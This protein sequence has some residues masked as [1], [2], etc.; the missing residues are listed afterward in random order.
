MDKGVHARVLL[1]GE[2]VGVVID[3]TEARLPSIAHW[4]ADPGELSDD[5][6]ADLVLAASPPVTPSGVDVPVRLAILPEQHTGWVGRPGLS[7]ARDG[8]DFSP[9][10]RCTTLRLDGA[11]VDAAAAEVTVFR[12]GTGIV[13]VTAQDEP[14]GLRLEIEI[15]L[16][17]GGVLR[18]RAT[19]T[20]T[21]VEPYRLDQLALAL[22]VPA[23]ARDLL[24][25][26]GRWGKERVPQRRDFTVGV[27]L[28]EGRRGRTGA[29]AATVL[30]AGEPGFGFRHGQVWG[31]HVGWS[32]N[33]VHYAERTGG[34]EQV[35]GGAELL[36]PGEV[37]LASGS[38]YTTPWLYGSYGDGLDE[39]ARRFHRYLR[40][41]PG[42]PASDRPVTLN[43]WEAV[44]FDH[45]LQPLVELA[46]RAAAVGVERFVLDDGWFGSRRDDHSG[47]GD[48]TVSADVWPDGLHPLVDRVR[49]LGMEFGL[50]VEPEMVNL[51]SDLARAHPDWVMA[52][53]ERLPVPSRHQQVLN[54]SLPECFDHVRGALLA[55]LDEYEI[56][57]LKWDHNR[58]LIDAG[59]RVDGRPAVHAQTLAAYRLMDELRAAHPGLEIE[60]C[61]SGGARIDF[62]VLEHTERVWVS[63]CID[64]HERQRMLRWTTQLI[65]PELMGSHIASPVSH[66]TGRAHPLNTR[67]ATAIFGHLGVE[68]DLRAADDADLAELGAW[69]AFHKRLRPL[70]LGG[71]LVRIDWPDDWLVA[72]GVVA[73]DRSV[74]LYSV[75]ALETQDTGTVGRLPLPGLDPAR[76][77]RVRPALVGRPPAALPPPWWRLDVDPAALLDDLAHKR[78]PR[79]VAS[80]EVGVVLTGAALATA[81]LMLPPMQPDQVVLYLAE[82]V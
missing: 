64:P 10:F 20:N 70:L 16:A 52:A 63:D 44:Y 80:D 9:L 15:Q 66:T 38:S 11:V 69:I 34:G 56:G 82:A 27:H 51:D 42:H 31:V 22:P 49:E 40:A 36:L 76:R 54:L 60:S 24:D 30:H 71:D 48:W 72:G 50:W 17:A 1:R 53:G 65:P 4:G 58:D 81:G 3:L 35:L 18:T 37:R 78:A 74:A 21:A 47:L 13:A 8:R 77:Y 7:G 68:W 2:G 19:L 59:G 25:F 32:G 75:A 57:Y 28:R 12:L 73:M 46:E 14:A 39:V 26:A 67:A 41:R 33:H 5:E 55:L 61:S 23:G 62:G 29:D 6:V 79:A 43:V 45:A